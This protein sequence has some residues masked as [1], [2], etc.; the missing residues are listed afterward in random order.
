M[1]SFSQIT[2]LSVF[3]PLIVQEGEEIDFR[4][5]ADSFSPGRGNEGFSV[6]SF[7]DGK[8]VTAKIWI[9]YLISLSQCFR[10]RVD[11]YKSKNESLKMWNSKKY[12]S[13]KNIF[14]YYYL[15][16]RVINQKQKHSPMTQYFHSP[17]IVL[18]IHQ[19]G[20]LQQVLLHIST[21]NNKHTQTWLEKNR[22]IRDNRWKLFEEILQ[23]NSWRKIKDIHTANIHTHTHTC[24]YMCVLPSDRAT[25]LVI[26]LDE[27]SKSAGVVVVG[28]LGIPKSLRWKMDRISSG[29]EG[30]CEDRM[31]D[32]VHLTF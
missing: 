18:L 13:E 31:I 17:L 30:Q 1:V 6:L 3:F 11:F 19:T 9:W 22:T 27:L 23:M 8:H 5:R 25:L 7:K 28:R 21:E 24:T 15:K 4:W 29:S 12:V 20:F 2:K 26:D 14:C 32:K 16:K 10:S